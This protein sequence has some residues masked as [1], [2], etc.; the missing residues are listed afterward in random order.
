MGEVINLNRLRKTKAK[1]SA[2]RQAEANRLRFGRSKDEKLRDNSIV[3][4][5]ERDLDGKKIE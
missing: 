5:A 3:E 1:E 2:A 4:R